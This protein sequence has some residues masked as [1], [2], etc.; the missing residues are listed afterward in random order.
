MIAWVVLCAALL[1]FV[2]VTS[3]DPPGAGDYHYQPGE[4]VTGF[5]T[6]LRQ[7][8]WNENA[9]RFFWKGETVHLE[10]FSGKILFIQFYDPF[11]TICLE[12]LNQTVPNIKGYYEERK[13]NAAGIPVV[14]MVINLEPAEYARYEADYV[15]PYSVDLRGND[16]TETEVD[17]AVRLFAAHTSKPVFVA[18]N[19]VANSPSHRQF[20]LLVNKSGVVESQIPDLITTWKTVIDSVEAPLPSLENVQRLGEGTFEFTFYGQ[21]NSIYRVSS[22][23]NFTDWDFGDPLVGTNGPMV[24]PFNTDSG[25]QRFFRV[26]SP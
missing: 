11:C 23:T 7:A 4:V 18:I 3:A 15:L 9:G 14:Y 10:D 16:Y 17:V 2:P 13:G 1:S 25:A 20:E 26:V 12:G 22:T 5:S 24:V 8:W 6:V 19:C 21:L